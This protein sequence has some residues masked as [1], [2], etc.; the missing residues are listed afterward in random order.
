MK[1]LIFLQ[2]MS[3]L[4]RVW[5]D[6]EQISV[7]QCALYLKACVMQGLFKVGQEGDR[8]WQRMR[9]DST[10]PRDT[11]VLST[12]LKGLC[13]E[14]RLDGENGALK[15][16]AEMRH[17]DAKN[18][19]IAADT[20]TFG[21][22]LKGLCF[23]GRSEEA[24]ECFQEAMRLPGC[25]PNAVALAPLIR[26]LSLENDGFKLSAVVANLSSSS[27]SFICVGSAILYAIVQFRFNFF[28]LI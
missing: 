7:Y 15:L 28:C 9:G 13:D 3:T 27:V 21:T 14:K 10:I 11:V 23:A 2:D 4:N 20:I 6:I 26:M 18:K 5:N 22:V 19:N 16:F 12:V 1:A 24:F 25:F 8:T 17:A